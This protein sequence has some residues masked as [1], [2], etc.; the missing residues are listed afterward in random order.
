A[1]VAG[2]MAAPA[3]DQALNM[4]HYARLKVTQDA[5]VEVIRAAYRVLA[6]KYHPDRHPI[7]EP[8]SAEAHAE[9]VALNTAYQV[10]V[11]PQSRR[12]YDAL[13]AEK[14]SL[15]KFKSA[16]QTTVVTEA[17]P[18][19][20]LNAKVDMEWLPPQTQVDDQPW[21]ANRRVMLVGVS[22]IGVLLIGGA[23]WVSQL[24]VQHQMEK[25]LSDQYAASP[26]PIAPIQ[27]VETR[28]PGVESVVAATHVRPLIAAPTASPAS[29]PSEAPS[30]PVVMD[31]STSSPSP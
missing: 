8:G 25:A 22:L 14:K 9:M 26:V 23:Y 30:Q 12:E 24:V 13:L 16:A 15:R 21:R 6:A 11:N 27:I 17:P 31:L 4:S 1:S 29:V 28:L 20:P 5:P 7:G 19:V 18:D 3:E 2:R 10:L